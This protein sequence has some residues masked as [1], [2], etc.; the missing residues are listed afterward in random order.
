MLLCCSSSIGVAP[1]ATAHRSVRSTQVL[2]SGLVRRAGTTGHRMASQAAAAAAGGA[3]AGGASSSSQQQQMPQYPTPP[4]IH[5]ATGN[6][7]KLEEVVAILG[8]GGELPFRVDSV[9]LDLPEL[10]VRQTG[11]DDGD[12]LRCFSVVFSRVCVF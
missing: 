12:G 2:G 8:A 3:G 7:K 1:L 5:F 4:V 10:Q 11:C 9:K 6:K